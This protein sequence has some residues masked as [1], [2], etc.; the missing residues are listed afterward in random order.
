MS[1]RPNHHLIYGTGHHGKNRQEREGCSEEGSEKQT[2]KPATI[3]PI[4]ETLSKSALVAHLAESSA[5][6]AKDVRTLLGALEN[7]IHASLHKKG[8]GS[9]TL[10]G[11]LKISTVNVPAKPKRKGI[12][13]FTKEEQWFAAKPASVKIK[14]RPLKSLKTRHFD[15]LR[16]KAIGTV[17]AI[18]IAFEVTLSS[19]SAVFLYMN[20]ILVKTARR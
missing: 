19:A 14:T 12:N 15:D 6:A 10:P 13:P 3:K 1:A 11:L 4:K 9:F 17:L 16:S 5:L 7:T 20:F 2:A 8:V 18:S